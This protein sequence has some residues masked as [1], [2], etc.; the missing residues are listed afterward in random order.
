LSLMDSFFQNPYG[1]PAANKP[2]LAW[3][4][5]YGPVQLAVAGG[6]TP[7]FPTREL[8]IS[9][10]WFAGFALLGL[11]IFWRRTRIWNARGRT[12][13]SAAPLASTVAP[14]V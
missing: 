14:R 3:F 7:V 9:F 11:A 2:F 12:L 8:L 1:N 4:P 5:S 10:A 13:A 6:F